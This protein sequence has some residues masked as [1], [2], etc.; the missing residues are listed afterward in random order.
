MNKEKIQSIINEVYPKIEKHYGYSKHHECT[1]FVEL[2]HNIYARITGVDHFTE[3]EC[4]PD[5]EFDRQDNTIV[6]YWPKAK[7][8]KWIIQTLIHEYQHY[9]QSPAWMKRY[10]SMGYEYDTHPYE[11]AATK[12]E[13]NWKTFA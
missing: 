1:P 12:A 4:D 3:G 6:I 8:K 9:L 5:A 2:H 7:D 10:Y 13:S 11:V